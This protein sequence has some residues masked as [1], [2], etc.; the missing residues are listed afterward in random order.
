MLT[1]VNF[2][3]QK[4]IE[5]TSYFRYGYGYPY[6]SGYYGH[7]VGKRS[8]DADANADAYHYGYNGYGLGSVYGYGYYPYATGYY[9]HYLGKRSADEQSGPNPESDAHGYYSR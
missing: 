6:H 8:A 5:F 4:Y 9:G 2:F 3:I 1:T 7:F